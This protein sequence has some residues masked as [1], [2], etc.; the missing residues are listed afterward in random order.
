MNADPVPFF[1]IVIPVKNEEASIPDLAR[2]IDTAFAKADFAWEVLWVDDGS[3]DST[4]DLLK[5]LPKPH[6]WISFARNFGQS[7]AFAA[8]FREAHGEWVGTLDG[9][10]Q[11]DPNDLLRQLA[12]GRANNVDMVNGIR[13]RRQD[14]FVR[15]LSSK[16]GNGT[17]NLITGKSVTDVGCSTRVVKRRFVA[18]MPFFHGNHRFIPTLAMMAGATIAEIPVN[19][20]QRHGGKSKYGISNRM[21]SGLRDCFGVR[22]LKSRH[23]AWTVASRAP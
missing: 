12:H 17:R 7:A 14:N 20:R 18:D 8:G 4:L 6:R 13:Q 21:F 22:W 10:G 1:S 11:N 15:K 19:H 16:I 2:E 23:R 5:A 3:N 9:D